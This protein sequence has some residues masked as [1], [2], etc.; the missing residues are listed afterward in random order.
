LQNP[1]GLLPKKGFAVVTACSC[2][3]ERTRTE[4]DLERS[5]P[6]TTCTLIRNWHLELWTEAH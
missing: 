6:D 2:R 1:K 3:V 5:E 4:V